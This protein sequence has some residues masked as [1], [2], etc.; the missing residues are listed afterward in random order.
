MVEVSKKKPEVHEV[1]LCF[2]PILACS[3]F[4]GPVWRWRG[5]GGCPCRRAHRS[6]CINGTVPCM[7]CRG[8]CWCV[9]S[10][11]VTERICLFTA[12]GVK[13]CVGFPK[14]S[15]KIFGE[16]SQESE[17]QQPPESVKVSKVC[18]H[19]PLLRPFFLPSFL[20]TTS[21]YFFETCGVKVVFRQEAV[22]GKGQPTGK[23]R[24]FHFPLAGCVGQSRV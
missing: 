19:R 12:L 1:S 5:A 21:L 3:L 22:G 14:S 7:W 9:L 15:V 16:I 24:G 23:Y 11:L 13:V 20:G 6:L 17:Y 18:W 8:L 4:V 10:T 2:L